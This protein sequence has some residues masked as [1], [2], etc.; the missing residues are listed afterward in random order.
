MIL[1]GNIDPFL[2]HSFHDKYVPVIFL[3]Y[4]YCSPRENCVQMCG[5]Q[6]DMSAAFKTKVWLLCNNLCTSVGLK[7]S[8]SI[9]FIFIVN[10]SIQVQVSLLVIDCRQQIFI[11]LTFPLAL[12]Y[13][14][15]MQ[16]CIIKL[17][18]ASITPAWLHNRRA[19]V[20]KWPACS[21]D[22]SPTENT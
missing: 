5:P 6:K 2:L 4:K 16:I 1:F 20:L 3:W 19:R 17:H 15:A 12:Q 13:I 11:C 21:P 8:V 7:K 18:A 14:I 9:F 10:C 22:F